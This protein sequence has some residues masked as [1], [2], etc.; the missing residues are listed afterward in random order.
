MCSL[1]FNVVMNIDTRYDYGVDGLYKLSE[2][3]IAVVEGRDKDRE[4]V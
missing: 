2:E 4:E 3:E 1:K